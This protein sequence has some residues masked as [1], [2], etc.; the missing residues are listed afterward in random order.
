MII[1]ENSVRKVIP[2]ASGKGGV[3]KSF[4]TANLGILLASYAKR[5]VIID[6]DLGGSNLH[7]YLGLKNRHK[8]IGNFISDKKLKFDDLLVETPYENLR[9]IPGDVL[10]AGTAN[11][12]QSQRDS[13]QKQILK[14][15]AD[16]I[17][18]DLGSGTSLNVIDFFLIA[19][20]G[21]VVT[22]PQTPSILNAYNFLKNAVFRHIQ[23]TVS[24][25]KQVSSYLKDVVKEQAP[26]STPTISKIVKGIQ[27]IDAEAG[28][29]AK[30]EVAQFHPLL[31]VNMADDAEDMDIVEN[32]RDL[33]LKNFDLRT[34]CMGLIYE[35]RAVRK[36]LK[37]MKPLVSNSSDSIVTLELDRMTQKLIQSPRFPNMPLDLN[38]Y[39]DS[40]ELARIEAQNDSPESHPAESSSEETGLSQDEF[41]QI[42]SAQKQQIEELQGTVRMLTMNQR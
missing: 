33:L 7:T 3:G 11:L 2:V 1:N 21:F 5:T 12:T 26:G 13:I 22:T 36:A 8:G 30:Q 39:R 18:L 23:R 32:L 9:F 17:L 14:L 35:D 19:N 38:E 16:Y 15:D 37:E 34:S 40:F 42:I 25:P 4:V 10:V 27:G 31:L 20:A 6:L 29:R 28:K 24:S 41:M